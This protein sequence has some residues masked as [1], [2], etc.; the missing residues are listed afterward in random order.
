MPMRLLESIR[1]RRR[2]FDVVFHTPS[3]STILTPASGLPPGGAETQ[4]LMLS[5]ALARLGLRVA[6]VVYRA[7]D[8]LPSEVEGVTIV[9]RPPQRKLRFVGKIVEALAVWRSLFR[10]PRGAIVKRGLGLELALIAVYAKLARRALIFSSANIVDF[11]P[12]HGM[13]RRR[14][15]WMYDFGLRRADVTV[16]QT[17]EQIP[18]CEQYVGRTPVLIKSLATVGG[19]PQEPEAFLWV[20]RLVSYKRP[21]D[22]LELARAL[23]DAKFWMVGVPTLHF[24]SDRQVADAAMAAAAELPNLE[25]LSPRP[26][27]EIAELMGRA[28]AS[29]NT[30]DFEGMPNV[31]LEAW[32]RGVPALVLTH[33]PGGVVTQHGLGGFANGSHEAFTA[34]AREL[35]ESRHDREELS[36]RCRAYIGEN[37]SPEV[38]A[39]QWRDVLARSRTRAPRRS[40]ACAG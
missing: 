25:L 22:Y 36:E 18:M 17:E 15:L 30:A 6:I 20:G 26:H 33:D 8:M 35:W 40:G 7:D 16:V 19:P 32:S 23:P 4:I 29:V 24:E 11:D 31:L 1:R 9:A 5:K 14:D 3:I 39:R 21:M 34:L 28:V 13:D 10:A 2:R 27:A 37:H 12:K 38:V